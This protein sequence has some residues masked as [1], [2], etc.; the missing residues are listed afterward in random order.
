MADA[1][2]RALDSEST[3]EID[4]IQFLIGSWMLSQSDA[5][6]NDKWLHWRRKIIFAHYNR[7]SEKNMNQ[8][9][10]VSF[11]NDLSKSDKPQLFGVSCHWQDIFEEKKKKQDEEDERRRDKVFH[12]KSVLPMLSLSTFD[13]T[14][15]L[16]S[17]RKYEIKK[18]CYELVLS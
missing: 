16:R 9:D 11:L 2:F 10:F 14:S 12:T 15:F 13:I 1:C 6:K 4:E 8:E 3:G 7:S 5:P 18:H 17:L